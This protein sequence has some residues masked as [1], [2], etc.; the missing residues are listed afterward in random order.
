MTEDEK[1]NSEPLAVRLEKALEK[2]HL[3]TF[4]GI[5]IVIGFGLFFIFWYMSLNDILIN[6]P[7]LDPFVLLGYDVDIDYITVTILYFVFILVMM[8]IV[9]LL[10]LLPVIL[11]VMLGSKS[12]LAFG[13]SQDTAKIGKKFGGIQLVL[14]GL[15][16]G[17]FGIGIG[18]G[19]L[20]ILM[21]LTNIH[22]S[23]W[24]LYFT[25]ISTLL[26]MILMV[27]ILV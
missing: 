19:A 21:P 18:L 11:F 1:T 6:H 24:P 5:L 2:K 9:Y 10:L 13:L 15:L 26:V 4:P 20:P 3:F 27:C 8:L 25:L 14:R 17:L 22:P 7:A 16:P 12:M 23:A